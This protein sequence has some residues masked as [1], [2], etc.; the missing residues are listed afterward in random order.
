MK[1][2]KNKRRLSF[3]LI[4]SLLLATLVNAGCGEAS[5][6]SPAGKNLPDPNGPPVPVTGQGKGWE[7]PDA[8]TGK[9]P[10]QN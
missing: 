2:K 10:A 9:S 1:M 8:G 7:T 3:S 5:V 4:A 6:S